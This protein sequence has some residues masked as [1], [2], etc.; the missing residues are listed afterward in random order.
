M[1]PMKPAIEG[2]AKMKKSIFAIIV[3]MVF[4]LAGAAAA[5][6]KVRVTV[7]N[8]NVRSQPGL[9]AKIVLKAG[10]DDVFEVL[11]RTAGWFKVRLPA[12]AGTESPEGY[13]SEDVAEIVGSAPAK[14]LDRPAG[15]RKTAKPVARGNKKLFSGSFA[16]FGSQTYP[17]VSTF[18]NRWLL[19]LGKDWG[20]NPFLAAGFEL[21]PYYRHSAV[22]DLSN[23]TFG[24]NI[25]VNAKGGV[26]V[27]RFVE[28]LK[29][30]TPYIGF[31]LGGAFSFS[32]SKAG[33]A[34][35]SRADLYFAWHMMF[36]LEVVLKKMSAILEFQSVKIS[37]P[38]IDP[39]Y[40][41][42]VLMLGIRF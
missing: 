33:S 14:G 5:S 23:S 2:E 41:Q 30:L 35:V 7:N 29:I 21:Q 22:L 25:F 15:P 24:A 4:C 20:I 8:A 42:Y 38:A 1:S 28:S 18:P 39:D 10:K 26:N 13:L 3:I 19:G 9:N 16:K 31:G 12:E 11:G 6:E 40:A 32:S 34:R 27:G 36:G 17:P 37:V